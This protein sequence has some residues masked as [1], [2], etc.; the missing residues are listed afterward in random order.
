MNHTIGIIVRVKNYVKVTIEKKLNDLF[1]LMVFFPFFIFQNY[2]WICRVSYIDST[3][4][5]VIL[6]KQKD[7]RKI[8]G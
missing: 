3:D 1:S 8:M 2:H 6:K 7:R 4:L 5:I